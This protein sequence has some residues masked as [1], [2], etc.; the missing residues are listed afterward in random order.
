[1]KK[2]NK[3]YKSLYSFNDRYNE[4]QRILEK[5]PDR[6]PIIC[7]RSNMTSIDCPYIDKNK[8]LV[9]NSLTVGQFLYVI[10]KRMKISENK[11]MFL[12]VNDNV[13]HSTQILSNTYEYYKDDE[14]FLYVSYSFENTFG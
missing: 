4:S 12:F 8:Y 2:Y 6:I 3:D 7:E 1:M 10:R 11:A 13:P 14:G 9:P 5:Y